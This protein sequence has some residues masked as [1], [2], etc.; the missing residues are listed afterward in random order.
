MY[1]YRRSGAPLSERRGR[2]AAVSKSRAAP[3]IVFAAALSRADES[4]MSPNRLRVDH[5]AEQMPP[6]YL[7]GYS[8]EYSTN[9]C[10][11]WA[12]VF[13]GRRGRPAGAPPG[14]GARVNK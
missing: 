11:V 1:D 10:G 9:M 6:F 14:G 8:P 13:S 12:A 4:L 5:Y 3:P 2:A 7:I